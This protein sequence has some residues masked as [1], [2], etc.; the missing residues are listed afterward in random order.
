MKRILTAL[1]LS[2]VLAS[3]A[4]SEIVT[5]K[6]I[7]STHALE[8]SF[9]MSLN[10]ERKTASF[11]Y[12]NENIEPHVNDIQIYDDHIF[13]SNQSPE[14]GYYSMWMLKRDSLRIMGVFLSNSS[15]YHNDPKKFVF[16]GECRRGI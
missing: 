12:D 1:T 7:T 2:A 10:F 13:G 14:N 15:W 11:E 9:K 4:W 6:C 8:T 5:I 16:G 3:P